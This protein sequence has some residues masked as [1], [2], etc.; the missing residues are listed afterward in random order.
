MRSVYVLT[1]LLI[2]SAIAVTNA[3]AS[4]SDRIDGLTATFDP[5]SEETTIHITLID[6]NDGDLLDNLKQASW[7]LIR[8]G[9]IVQQQIHLCTM[10]MTNSEC[11]GSQYNLT[12]YPPAGSNGEATYLVVETFLGWSTAAPGVVE[13]VSPIVG[14]E[15]LTGT[16]SDDV[17]TL[18]WDYPESIAMNHSIMIYSHES[19]A[20][21]DN[22]NS[23][24]KTI[25]SSSVAAG[26]TNFEINH[27]SSSVERE[28]YYSVTLLYETSED[29]RFLGS[30]TLTVPVKEDNIAPLFV[31]ELTATFNSELDMTTIDWG[32]GISDEDLMINIYRSQMELPLLD[33]N[34]LVATV[35][36]SLSSYQ[37][38]VPMGEH[39]QSWYAITLIDSQGNE[40]LNLS[41]SSPVAEPVIESTIS[42]SQISNLDVERHVDGT[43][44]INWDDTSQSPNAIAKIWRSITG[45]IDSFDDIEELASTDVSL[46]QYSHNP[47]NS[48]DQAWYAVTLEG[49]WGSS[50]IP[51]HDDTL[52]TGGNSMENPFRETE[53]IIEEPVIEF[54][55]QVQSTS[56][57][58]GELSDGNLIS[59]GPMYE[60][61]LIIISTSKEVDNIS[62]NDIAGQGSV[63]YS[64]SDWALSF[65]ANQSGEACYG[66]IIDGDDEIGFT[67]TWNY[68]ENITTVDDENI[69]DDTEQDDGPAENKGSKESK[70]TIAGVILSII[71]LALLVYLLVMVKG[72]QYFEEE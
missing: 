66:T 49:V 16:Y 26:T 23:L 40:I 57:A 45:P 18:S 64:Q 35:A 67:M 1:A 32:A 6:T 68:I 19:L 4:S 47:L 34:N 51:W 53:E 9:I 3:A 21:R 30:N 48:V 55:A 31:G 33:A 59:L 41:E 20:T 15:N 38:E 8:D 5:A 25:V 70:E 58:G 71:I 14:I 24:T 69:E 72:P 56:G 54:L 61:D 46:E 44:T 63:I 39:R 11:S 42:S 28:I 43:I 50:T 60:G 12:H 22:W 7:S 62:C 17:T 52:T 65:S 13:S 29:T 37:V 2:F 27:S 10:A 36:S